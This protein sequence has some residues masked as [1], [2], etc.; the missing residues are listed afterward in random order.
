MLKSGISNRNRYKL[1]RVTNMLQFI[2]KAQL[3]YQEARA[4][5]AELRQER[6][7]GE[8][9]D[10]VIFCEHPALLSYGKRV[11]KTEVHKLKE[12]IGDKIPL[13]FAERGGLFTY[14]GPGQLIVYPVISLRERV[15]GVKKFSEL[16]LE[17]VSKVVR[18]FGVIS[19]VSLCPAGVW[20]VGEGGGKRKIA[21]LGLRIEKGISDHGMSLNIDCDMS[22]FRKISPCGLDSASVSSLLESGFEI[23]REL[24]VSRLKLVLNQV[25]E[26]G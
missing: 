1:E 10:T 15:L 7:K 4:L 6:R 3:E 22:I 16:L 19:N 18:Q 21:S 25:F 8:I 26:K 17:A 24:L 20:L 2:D 14:H 11:S 9:P 13:V 23:D 12:N 5:Q